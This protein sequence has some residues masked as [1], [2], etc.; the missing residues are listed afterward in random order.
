M[1]AKASLTI[2]QGDDYVANVL[3]MEG[4]GVTPADLTGFTAQ[5]QM[6][7]NANDTSPN[8][9]AEFTIGIT[10]NLITLTLTNDVTRNLS[11]PSYIWDLQ[12][13]APNGWI[14]TLLFGNIQVVREVTKV[15]A[16]AGRK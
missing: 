2:Y 7:V 16:A 10:G 4:D 15:Y 3:V 13:I 8:G 11:S 6:R 12:I 9:A 14:T 1:A 5:S